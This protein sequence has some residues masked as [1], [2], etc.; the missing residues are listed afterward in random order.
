MSYVIIRGTNRKVKSYYKNFLFKK[1]S[2]AV[3]SVS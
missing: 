3:L 1:I 2:Q